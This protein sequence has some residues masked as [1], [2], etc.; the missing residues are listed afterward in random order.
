MSPAFA[1]MRR[2][3]FP[4]R[5]PVWAR[6]QSQGVRLFGF[7][8]LLGLMALFMVAIAIACILAIRTTAF[9]THRGEHVGSLVVT[10]SFGVLLALLVAVSFA[11]VAVF[12]K[13]FVV[14]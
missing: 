9:W 8:L 1:H 11:V 12:T 14:P 2:I 5:A 10:I 7:H 6:R 4:F 3:L 13:D